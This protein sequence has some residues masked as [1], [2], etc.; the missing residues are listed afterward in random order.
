MAN[1]VDFPCKHEN[2]V[3]FS[4]E[5]INKTTL[6]FPDSYNNYAALATLA[7]AMKEA[8]HFPFCILPFCHTIEAEALGGK[9]NLG[10]G[11][12][13]PRPKEYAYGSI[14]ELMQTSPINFSRGR[15][16][17]V[18]LACSLLKERGEKVA[19]EIC[20]PF[21]ILNCLMDIA[22]FFKTWRKDPQLAEDIFSF[23]SDNL[24]NYIQAACETG[25]DIISYADS[26]GSLKI[27]GPRYTEKTARLFTVPFLNKA[28]D[29][30][31]GKC[32]IQLCPKTTLILTGLDL[33][34]FENI[35][36]PEKS[37]Y[38]EAVLSVI[39]RT[40]IVG[41]ACLKEE[42]FLSNGNIKAIRLK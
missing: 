29:I 27:L 34:Q 13:G 41:Q 25:V 11:Q 19:L 39:G 40:D 24:L 10:N 7:V 42:R 36:I 8:M 28:R 37:T 26:A 35:S 2:A 31:A 17:Q 22:L 30:T 18:L 9:I 14:E 20:G 38:A 5:I 3:G 33:A 15:I 12:I 23:I 21:T 1:L 6:S 32:L 4:D 16:H